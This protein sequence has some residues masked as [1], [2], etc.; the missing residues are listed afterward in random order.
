M[1]NLKNSA[2]YD[3]ICQDFYSQIERLYIEAIQ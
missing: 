2:F 1:Q 3:I